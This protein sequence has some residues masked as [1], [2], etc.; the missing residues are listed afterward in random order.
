MPRIFLSEEERYNEYIG[1]CF[2]KNSGFEKEFVEI[3]IPFVQKN[4]IYRSLLYVYGNEHRK[5]NEETLISTNDLTHWFESAKIQGGSP[6]LVCFSNEIIDLPYPVFVKYS[7]VAKSNN[8]ILNFNEQ[9]R[10]KNMVLGLNDALDFENKRNA[11]FWRDIGVNENMDPGDSISSRK[12]LIEKC[13]ENDQIAFVA[14]NMSNMSMEEQLKYKFIFSREGDDVPWI[15]GSNSVL[16]MPSP[17]R[18][19]WFLEDLLVP[20]V[21]Y[22]QVKNDFSDVYEKIEWG[23]QHIEECKTMSQNGKAWIQMFLDKQK[24]LELHCRLLRTY[25]SK[26]KFLKEDMTM[27]KAN[28]IVN[29]LYLKYLDRKADTTGLS[30]YAQKLV[31]YRLDKIHVENILQNSQE[32]KIRNKK[33][34]AE[35]VRKYKKGDAERIVRELYLKIFNREVDPEGKETYVKK[36]RTG[37]LSEKE[38]ENIL[39]ESEEHKLL[40]QKIHG[41]KLSL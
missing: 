4:H 26:I 20:D 6:C 29:E 37:E 19:T 28:K 9:Y 1:S 13:A 39:L 32:F 33:I 25:F 22:I 10:Y 21:H 12:I 17:T 34:T 40:L 41:S 11:L 31:S 24:E 3:S 8:V 27:E 38:F 23:I 5:E 36:L 18:R 15:L 14:E 16:I 30:T 7:S 2:K 35:R